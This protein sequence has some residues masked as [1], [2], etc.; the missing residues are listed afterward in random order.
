MLS[1]KYTYLLVVLSI[2]TIVGCILSYFLLRTSPHAS[3]SSTR[4]DSQKNQLSSLRSPKVTD[5]NNYPIV[6]DN[7]M[8]YQDKTNT[9]NQNF[10]QGQQKLYTAIN[11]LNKINKIKDVNSGLKIVQQV[12]NDLEESEILMQM[13]TADNIQYP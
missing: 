7:T 6:S 12:K 9:D 10:I 2:S 4:K 13:V 8:N 5:F 1:R 3:D 11:Q